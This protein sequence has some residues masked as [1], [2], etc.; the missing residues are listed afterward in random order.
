MPY[1]VTDHNSQDFVLL[2]PIEWKPRYIATIV[3]DEIGETLPTLTDDDK[4]RIPYDIVP[5]IRIR[6]CNTV[7]VV[8]ENYNTKLHYLLGPTWT[9]HAD[10]TA[11]ATWT[12]T[13][14][15]IN[16]VKADLRNIIAQNRY[17]KEIEGFVTSLNGS[18]VY[19]NTSRELR[20]TYHFRAV[21][22]SDTDTV[23]WKF[24][25]NLIL[26]LSKT[27]LMNLTSLIHNHV[28]QW[29]DWE[30]GKVT[31]INNCTTLDQL[32]NIELRT[33]PEVND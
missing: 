19:V 8:Q 13:D 28:Q 25:D 23:S 1:V 3:G 10:G 4:A 31:E 21:T 5:G 2:G 14:K 17:K 22:M 12:Q 33:D 27:D 32:K 15:D 9:Y 11:T 24:T 16:L 30:T 18:D 7:E 26:S 20:D 29:F 6:E